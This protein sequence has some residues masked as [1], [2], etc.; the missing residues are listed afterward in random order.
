M[1]NIILFLDK[2]LR[3][4]RNIYW[5]LYPVSHAI[6]LYTLDIPNG[7]HYSWHDRL[8]HYMYVGCVQNI[9][10]QKSCMGWCIVMLKYPPP[11]PQPRLRRCLGMKGMTTCLEMLSLYQAALTFPL[12]K[13]HTHMC[14][15]KTGNFKA[16]KPLLRTLFSSGNLS[17]CV[18]QL[19]QMRGKKE[20]FEF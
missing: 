2:T 10:S 16:I 19:T 4:L 3:Q 18:F 6:A 11:H 13:K 14:F 5:R 7:R 1:L 15:Y 12:S 8:H 17:C 9:F 20:P